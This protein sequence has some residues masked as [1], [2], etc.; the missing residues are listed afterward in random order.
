MKFEWEKW[1][2][3]P[4][5]IVLLLCIF[6]SIFISLGTLYYENQAQNKVVYDHLKALND[7]ISPPQNY[8]GP[9]DKYKE[10]QLLDDNGQFSSPNGKEMRKILLK[11]VSMLDDENIA[12][13]HKRLLEKNK[14]QNERLHLQQKY[15][16]LG[17]EKW[18]NETNIK[19]QL[20]IS[21]W[22]LNRKI[23][24]QNIEI[25]QKGFYFVYFLLSHWMN[26]FIIIMI[27]LFF[28]DFIPSEYERKNYLFLAVQPLKKSTIFLRKYMLT[29]IVLIGGMFGLL[30]VGFTVASIFH[31]T[32]S[33]AYPMLIKQGTS[34]H[35]IPL[36]EYFLKTVSLQILFML[37]SSSL[38]LLLSKWL[39]SG[40]EVLGLYLAIM[41]IP[42]FLEK[43]I[44]SLNKVTAWL[45]FFY[46]NTNSKILE[47]NN[48]FSSSFYFQFL[49]LVG[50]NL[51]LGIIW[52]WNLEDKH[53]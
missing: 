23:P 33:L 7:E 2:K 37:F 11:I 25:G 6:L 48:H 17:G 9:K 32:G 40:L 42:N 8:V 27:G 53:S 14:L 34:F 13:S 45:P 22:L 19:E 18:I 39:K 52:Y 44:P 38:L 4:K 5:N 1:I 46:M 50:W 29:M 20:A 51:I 3:N 12:H 30:F 43:M 36:G 26:Y 41:L 49:I 10:L 24:M 28:F 31:G 47:V 15:L 16:D 21:T 35:L